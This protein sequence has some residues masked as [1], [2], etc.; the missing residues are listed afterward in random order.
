MW[1]FVH[2]T[3]WQRPEVMGRYITG[4][5]D[6]LVISV[7]N[8]LVLPVAESI[9]FNRS[10]ASCIPFARLALSLAALTKRIKP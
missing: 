10:L 8:Q 4:R 6:H 7:C 9:L 1:Q 5:I 2:G 3:N